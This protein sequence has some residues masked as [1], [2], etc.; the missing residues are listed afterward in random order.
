MVLQV[1]FSSLDEEHFILTFFGLQ[2]SVIKTLDAYDCLLTLAVVLDSRQFKHA[3][4]LDKTL[5]ESRESQTCR[6]ARAVEKILTQSYICR[7]C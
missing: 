5:G 4:F 1:E 6:V 7:C 3:G 2:H